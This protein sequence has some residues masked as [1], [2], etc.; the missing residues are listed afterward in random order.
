[1]PRSIDLILISALACPLAFPAWGA[2][3]EKPTPNNAALRQGV[4]AEVAPAQID[5]IIVRFREG[6]GAG[7]GPE[8]AAAL[9]RE[10]DVP[11]KHATNTGTD[12]QIFVL[13]APVSIDQARSIAERIAEQPSVQYAEPDVLLQTQQANDTRFS[14]QWDF[15]EAGVGI[16]LA[17]AWQHATGT[18]AVIAIIDTGILPHADIAAQ[19][20]PGY[21]FISIVTVANDGDG[22]DADPTDAG[23]WCPPNQ[24]LSSWHGLHVAGTVAAVTDNN[25][26]VA[27]IARDGRILPVRA[28]GKCGGLISDVADGILWAAGLHVDGVPDNANP[29]R[30]INL[31]VGYAGAC[32]PTFTDAIRD[33]RNIGVT[34]VVAAG[35]SDIDASGFRPANCDGV[36]TVA[37]TN[38]QGGRAFFGH[39][40]SGSNFG[41]VV[42]IAAPGGEVH[43]HD[44]D[45]ILSLLNAG[46]TSAAGDDYIFYRGT[47]M[48]APHVAGVAGLLYGANPAITPDEV[49]SI[50]QQT[51]QP[52]PPVAVRPCNTSECGAGILDAGAA[53]SFALQI[54]KRTTGQ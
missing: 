26:G 14:E 53:V 35:N 43:V 4:T 41:S 1:M 9:S 5:R 12:A 36:V 15:V 54:A 52:F 31:S 27:G 10:L 13:E 51:S 37:A 25:L 40:G 33:A 49:V 34:V 2:G 19:I 39:A 32:G 50:L 47:S 8:N 23:D 48:A 28:V 16:N 3:A 29:A 38:R 18:G 45:G 20:L 11:L 7:T 6:R 17:P 44:G 46:L 22:R 24:P 30:V 42:E 21:D